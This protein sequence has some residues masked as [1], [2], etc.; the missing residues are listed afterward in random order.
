MRPA[1]TVRLFPNRLL[2]VPEETFELHLRRTGGLAGLPMT[3]TLRASDLAPAEAARVASA[4]NRLDDA[5]V[6]APDAPGAADGFCYELA[7][8]RDGATRTVAFGERGQ[9]P[10]LGPA[11]RAL[12]DRLTLA[13]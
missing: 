12:T 7:V 5:T 10:G 11:L 4:L 1:G 2:R 8:V 9:P 6:A 13:R 3:A